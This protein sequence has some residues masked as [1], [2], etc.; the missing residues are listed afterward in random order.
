M[1]NILAKLTTYKAKKNMIDQLE[2]ELE[3]LKNEIVEYM[4]GQEE[5]TVGQYKATNKDCTRNGIDE[6]QLKEK[7]PVIAE[8]MKKTTVYKRFSVK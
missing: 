5:I 3:S 2:K 7:Y 6:K 4:N 1:K 8:E